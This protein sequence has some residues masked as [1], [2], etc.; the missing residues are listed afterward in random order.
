VLLFPYFQRPYLTPVNPCGL[1][2]RLNLSDAKVA[3]LQAW[4][5]HLYCYRLKNFIPFSF[6]RF[7][8]IREGSAKVEEFLFHSKFLSKNFRIY[9]PDPQSLTS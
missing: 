7:A 1:P 9:F 3:N 5:L 6:S 8:A 2:L 4:C